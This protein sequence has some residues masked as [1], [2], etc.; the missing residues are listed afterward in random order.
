MT[1]NTYTLKE[2][3]F[4][5]YARKAGRETVPVPQCGML[6]SGEIQLQQEQSET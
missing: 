3:G 6:T 5:G 2:K 4:M 1:P